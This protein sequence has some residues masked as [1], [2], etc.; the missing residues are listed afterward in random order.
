M[1]FSVKKVIQIAVL[2]VCAAII[3]AS[4]GETKSDNAYT[5]SGIL[6]EGVDSEWVYM[7]KNNEYEHPIDSARIK[8]GGFVLKGAVDTVAFVTLHAGAVTDNPAFS[9]N[10]ILEPGAIAVDS[11]NMFASGTPLND[12]LADWMG[13]LLYM[14]DTLLHT[15]FMEHWAEHSGDFLGPFC[16]N[17]FAPYLDFSFV[18][19]LMSATDPEL[20]NNPTLAPFY[21]QLDA[22]REMQPGKTFKDIELQ[23]LQGEAVHLS[24]YIGKGDKVL[25]DFWASWCGPCRQAIPEIQKV[26]AKHKDIKVLGVAINDKPV[27]TQKAIEQLAITWPVISDP[28]ILT[29]KAYGFMAI[30]AMILFD[31]DGVILARDFHVDGLEELLSK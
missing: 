19:S 9:W 28:N 6:P 26:I 13:Q 23:T 25:V 11:A 7:Y 22:V 2:S 14:P 21:E 27:N 24:D 16:L 30:P 3:L 15:F 29:A 18:D 4:C 1:V 12:G 10:L 17:V 8:D 20:R 31:A 5:I